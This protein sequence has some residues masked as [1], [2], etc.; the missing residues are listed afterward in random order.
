LSACAT[1]TSTTP[2]A[3]A[4]PSPTGLSGADL[5]AWASVRE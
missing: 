5:L 4:I 2:K 3:F 1:D